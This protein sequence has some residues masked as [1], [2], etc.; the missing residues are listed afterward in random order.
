MLITVCMPMWPQLPVCLTHDLV[1][2]F[3]HLETISI[4]NASACPKKISS[5]PAFATIMLFLCPAAS[6]DQSTTASCCQLGFHPSLPFKLD[7]MHVA[8]HRLLL[9]PLAVQLLG[10][11]CPH[12]VLL[13]TLLCMQGDDVPSKSRT[14]SLQLHPTGPSGK[15]CLFIRFPIWLLS[16]FALSSRGVLSGAQPFCT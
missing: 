8:A 3:L 16:R 12:T 2:S 5:M 9:S 10:C 7:P 14:W 11:Y 6:M 13:L 15:L 4:K 1:S